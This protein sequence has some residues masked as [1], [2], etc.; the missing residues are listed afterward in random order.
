M[1]GVREPQPHL[2]RTPLGELTTLSQTPCMAEGVTNL[3]PFSIPS[4]VA[5]HPMPH[6]RKKQEQQRV[7]VGAGNAQSISIR[8]VSCDAATLQHGGIGGGA[9]AASAAAAPPPLLLCIGNMMIKN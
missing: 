9:A 2:P 7:A 6:S 1:V 5:L 3:S 4:T 8:Q